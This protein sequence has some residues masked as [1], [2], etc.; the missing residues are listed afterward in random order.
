MCVI[1]LHLQQHR[2]GVHQLARFAAAPRWAQ[3][4]CERCAAVQAVK[5]S[6]WLEGKLRSALQ[7]NMVFPACTDI[8]LSFLLDE[9]H[10]G[11]PEVLPLEV[12]DGPQAKRRGSG[13]VDGAASDSGKA[14]GKGE[15]LAQAEKDKDKEKKKE[16]KAKAE[17][18]SRTASVLAQGGAAVGPADGA[19][20]KVRCVEC[21][22]GWQQREGA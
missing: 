16:G 5:L 18:R 8:H 22:F 2:N 7:R 14:K 20:D 4:L 17:R 11:T 1:C 6:G 21:C 9:H 13:G 19:M 12:P 3:R 10:L 15:K